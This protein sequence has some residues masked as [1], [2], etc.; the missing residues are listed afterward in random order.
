M[1]LIWEGSW[2]EEATESASYYLWG[3]LELCGSVALKSGDP[4]SADS[5]VFLALCSKTKRA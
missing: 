4:F 2:E 5:H 3:E 1:G